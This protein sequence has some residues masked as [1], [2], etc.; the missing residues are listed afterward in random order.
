MPTIDIQSILDSKLRTQK[1]AI[2]V[3]GPTPKAALDPNH[4][5]HK[6]SKKRIEIRDNLRAQGHQAEFPED[7]LQGAN[8][9]PRGQVLLYE[10]ILVLNNDL[11]V[12]IVDSPGSNNELGYFA[13]KSEM[14]A[15]TQAFI[16]E[17]YKGGLPDDTCHA[18][19]EL[20]GVTHYYIYPDDIDHCHLWGMVETQVKRLQRRKLYN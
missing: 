11:V 8:I 3:F 14:A 17:A 10:E 2:L 5:S 12:M 18:L 6:L 9:P 7:L 20:G 16:N 4:P 15:K 13:A 1:L 19:Q